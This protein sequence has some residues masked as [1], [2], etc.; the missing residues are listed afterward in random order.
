MEKKKRVPQFQKCIF[1]YSSF[2][3]GPLALAFQR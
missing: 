1:L 3:A 2:S